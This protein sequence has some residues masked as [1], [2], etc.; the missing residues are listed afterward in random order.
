MLHAM[1]NPLSFFLCRAHRATTLHRPEKPTGTPFLIFLRA[2]PFSHPG[3][4]RQQ[5]Y[6]FLVPFEPSWWPEHHPLTGISP[7]HRHLP[8]SMVRDATVIPFHSW[9]KLVC[10]SPHYLSPWAT[11]P[12]LDSPPATTHLLHWWTSPPRTE[13]ATTL[14]THLF[15]EPLPPLTC[16]VG[17]PC[18]GGG[19]A[20]EIGSSSPTSR[21]WCPRCLTSHACGNHAMGVM[22]CTPLCGSCALQDAM[23]HRSVGATTLGQIRPNDRFGFRFDFWTSIIHLNIPEISSNFQKIIEFCRNIRKL[24]IEFC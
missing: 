7:R 5:H 8:R 1:S 14:T 24:W 4:P 3:A 9:S 21:R 15:G 11:G 16:P 19:F 23:G 17:V 6:S 13:P 2:K 20:A 10:A 18:H 22:R 12:F